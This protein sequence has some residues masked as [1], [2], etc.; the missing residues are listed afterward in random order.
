M[1]KEKICYS[2]SFMQVVMAGSTYPRLVVLWPGGHIGEKCPRRRQPG[3]RGR[4]KAGNPTNGGGEGE[5]RPDLMNTGYNIG[6]F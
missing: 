3:A 2:S 5:S 1:Q 4:D 6:K